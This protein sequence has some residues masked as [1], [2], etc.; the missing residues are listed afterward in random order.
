MNRLTKSFGLGQGLAVLVIALTA[1]ACKAVTD[2]DH[3][4]FGLL[5]V[6]TITTPQGPLDLVLD[7]DGYIVTADQEPLGRISVGGTFGFGEWRLSTG[8]Y[9]V[10]LTDLADNCKGGER[11][12][13][14]DV[15]GTVTIKERV[16]V[17][18]GFHVICTCPA[19]VRVEVGV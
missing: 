14:F 15:G 8:T 6:S 12:G 2:V 16:T 11:S 3:P 18:I 17:A 10:A 5:R 19:E 7:P 9:S 13:S 1:S 4:S